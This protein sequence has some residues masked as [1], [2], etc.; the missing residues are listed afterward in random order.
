MSDECSVVQRSNSIFAALDS[1][2]KLYSRSVTFGNRYSQLDS[3]R[4]AAAIGIVWLHT[5]EMS[6]STSRLGEIGRFSVPFFSLV[7]MLLMGNAVHNRKKRRWLSYTWGRVARIGI[8][9]LIWT[10]IYVCLRDVKHIVRPTNVLVPI[11]PYLLLGGA[12]LQLWFLPFLLLVSFVCFPVQVWLYSDPQL[13]TRMSAMLR[14]GLG[15]LGLAV[16]FVADPFRVHVRP[17]LE[18]QACYVAAL[19]WGA[20]PSVCW[21]VAIGPTFS[22]LRKVRSGGGAVCGVAFLLCMFLVMAFGRSSLL[23]NT[24]ALFLLGLVFAARTR[25]LLA[26][27]GYLGVCSFGIY[28]IHAAAGLGLETFLL[29]NPNSARFGT[30]A[31]VFVA[32]LLLSTVLTWLLLQNRLTRWLVI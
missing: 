29:R 1:D 25:Q 24:S 18:D 14:L 26:V 5:M 20:L 30:I 3:G 2:W 12:S 10:A 21:G 15:A 28:L 7:A 23:E 31:A 6:A 19:G 8:P 32:S 4:F 13:H 11:T 17:T 27:C 22:V 16:C 9:L